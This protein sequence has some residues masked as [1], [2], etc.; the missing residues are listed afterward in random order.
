MSD[1]SPTQ[2]NEAAEYEDSIDNAL[3]PQLRMMFR[4]LLASPVR[5]AL[6]ALGTLLVVVVAGVAYGQNRLNTW[7]KPFY[8]ALSRHDLREFLHQLT[9][10]GVIAGS[11]L[12]LNVAQRWLGETLKL[13]LREGLMSDLVGIWLQP[14]RA[15]RLASAGTIGINPDQRMHEDARHL[16]ELSADL[17]IGLLQSSILLGTFVSVLWVISE[18]FSL[19]ISGHAISI[20]G[21]MVWAAVFYAGLASLLSYTVGKSL[22]TRNAERYAREADLRFSLVRVNEHIDAVALA[23][24]EADEARR[25]ELD[26]EAVFAAIRR[27]VRGLTNLTW[28]TAGYGWFTLVA[29]ILIATPMYFSGR[30]SFGGLMM[31]AGAFTQ[32]QS[33]LRWFVDNFSAI[34]DWRATLLRVANFRRAALNTDVLYDVES[35]IAYEEG[36]PGHFRIEHLEIASPAGCTMLEETSVQV[37][38]GERVLIVGESGAGKTL[39]FR[40]LAGLWPWGAGRIVRP[41]NESTVFVPR[42][43]YL[44]PGTLREILAYPH[45]AAR[46]EEQAMMN[47]LRRV[48]LRRLSPLLDKTQRW[49]QELSADEQQALAFARVM[50]HAPAWIFID[51]VLDTLD[52]DIRAR[53][54]DMLNHELKM[55]GIICI[56]RAP[57]PGIHCTR[58]LHLVKD[59]TIR[60]LVRRQERLHRRRRHKQEDV[61]HP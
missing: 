35:H 48:G 5:N 24:G 20:P 13:K 60:R 14:R 39:L 33:S 16:T 30:L 54:V 10:F 11:L 28:V 4:A 51:E 19:V 27:L 50:L 9:V 3:I 6:L 36:P 53:V 46:F 12:V 40:A 25:I 1:S 37:Q 2:P 15:F 42:S 45:K 17:G 43:A 57:V 18:G 52:A 26:M 55:T 58:T 47:A 34:A 59:P 38:A 21:Y 7:N 29:P 8:D 22:V 23:G 61:V 31:A 41:A 56:G 44:P 32:V 49:N